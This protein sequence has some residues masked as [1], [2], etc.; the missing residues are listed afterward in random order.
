MATGECV[1]NVF[2]QLFW[3]L[4]SYLK[5]IYANKVKIYGQEVLE[6]LSF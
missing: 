3:L 2:I 5:P 4:T 1:F 6:I